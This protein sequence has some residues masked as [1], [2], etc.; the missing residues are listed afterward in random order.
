LR[1]DGLRRVEHRAITELG[2]PPPLELMLYRQPGVRPSGGSNL[3]QDARRPD[4]S[5]QPSRAGRVKG[6]SEAALDAAEHSGITPNPNAAVDAA[7]A[8]RAGHGSSAMRSVM[9]DACTLF[10]ELPPMADQ[11][12]PILNEVKSA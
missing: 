5:D 10:H 9:S 8:A 3:L 2:N 4:H 11:T 12:R 7:S 1:I 6:S